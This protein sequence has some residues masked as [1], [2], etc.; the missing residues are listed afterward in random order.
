MDY[1]GSVGKISGLN[2]SFKG[3]GSVDWVKLRKN[4]GEEILSDDFKYL[5]KSNFKENN[6]TIR[7]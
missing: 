3:S 2:V 7:A 5:P 6:T 1:T 4:S